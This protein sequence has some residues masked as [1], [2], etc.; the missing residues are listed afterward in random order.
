MISPPLWSEIF[1]WLT[2][3]S[4]VDTVV[5]PWIFEQK[6]LEQEV[7]VGPKF[8]GTRVGHLPE[9]LTQYGW[10]EVRILPS[11]STAKKH[12]LSVNFWLTIVLHVHTGVLEVSF[13]WLIKCLFDSMTTY[14]T[15]Q[16]SKI[17]DNL[18]D[19]LTGHLWNFEKIIYQ[20]IAESKWSIWEIDNLCDWLVIWEIY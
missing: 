12:Q 7:K 1:C 2:F 15:E 16:L 20:L 18:N 17:I 6:H 4:V 11:C 8:I 14:P 13:F 3:E 10:R 9:Q 19:W 5:L